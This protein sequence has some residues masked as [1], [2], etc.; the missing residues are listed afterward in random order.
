M[1]NPFSA[2]PPAVRGPLWMIAAGLGY[3]LASACT[4]ELSSEYSTVQLAFL[5][6]LIAVPFFAPMLFRNGIGV[7]RTSVFP[8]HLFRALLTYGAMLS[9]FYAVSDIPVSDYTALL[10]F[11]LDQHTA[12]ASV[13]KPVKVATTGSGSDPCTAP[14]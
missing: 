4:R 13:T 11:L 1:K 12:F 14:E 3:T 10:M 7:L 2:M 5:R 6:S 9:W 8:M